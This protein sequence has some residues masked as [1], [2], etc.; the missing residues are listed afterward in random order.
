MFILYS[1]CKLAVEVAVRFT[2]RGIEEHGDR[3]DEDQV[4][5]GRLPRADGEDGEL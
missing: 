1:W 2:D 3:R 4:T 5:L